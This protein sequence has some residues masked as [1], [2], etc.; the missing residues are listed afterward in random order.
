MNAQKISIALF[1]FLRKE[2][3]RILRIWKQTL[4]PSVVTTTLYFLI[5]GTFI[6]SKLPPIG[7][8][9]YIQFIVPGLVMLA[10]ITNSF[11]NT[12]STFFFAKFQKNI[13]EILV[14]PLPYWSVVLGYLL[15][16]LFRGLLVGILVLFVALFFTHLTVF[17]LAIIVIFMILTSFL[18]S[19]AGLL[20]GLFAEGMDDVSIIPTFVLTPLTYLGGVFYSVHML[21]PIWQIV[22]RFNPILYIVDGFRYGFLGVSDVSIWISLSILI[23]TIIIFGTVTLYLFKNGYGLKS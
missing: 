2:V 6:G 17:N 16:G 15:G 5:F 10:V 14:S 11:Q 12:I 3:V 4:L 9:T 23:G 22:S 7:T 19:L 18:F 21:P 13:E 1:T 8:F 20:N